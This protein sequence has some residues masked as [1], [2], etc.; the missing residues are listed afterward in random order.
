MPCHERLIL[1]VMSCLVLLD[2][3]TLSGEAHAN[4]SL[5]AET[6]VSATDGEISAHGWL[7]VLMSPWPMLF[8]KQKAGCLAI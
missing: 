5:V 1:G 2:T 6:G 7:D 3:L 8:L 4:L